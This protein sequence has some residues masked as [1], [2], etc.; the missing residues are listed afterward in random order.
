[1]HAPMSTA[2]Y[3]L[4][5]ALFSVSAIVVAVCFD[6]TQ[7]FLFQKKN[8]SEQKR[9]GDVAPAEDDAKGQTSNRSKRPMLL[10]VLRMVAAALVACLLYFIPVNHFPLIYQVTGAVGVLSVTFPILAGGLLV[11]KKQIEKIPTFALI[12]FVCVTLSMQASYLFGQAINTKGNIIYN[13]GYPLLLSISDWP[14]FNCVMAAIAVLTR[15]F[16]L[17]TI[18]LAGTITA[19]LGFYGNFWGV[20]CDI[21]SLVFVLI[22]FIDRTVRYGSH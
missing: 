1:M 18:F 3:G 12:A 5:L 4:V 10:F 6:I 9:I 15:N 11:S 14:I 22:I 7:Y 20:Y 16:I 17:V 19:S 2:L 13:G 8:I 21:P